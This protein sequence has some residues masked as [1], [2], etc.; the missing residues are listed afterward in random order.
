VNLSPERWQ[1]IA[2]I[3]QLAVEVAPAAR[4]AFLSE[5]CGSDDDLRREV[6]SL[7]RQD[8]A[9]V[10][11]DRSVWSMA[12]PLLDDRFDVDPGTALG[13]Y[14]IDCRL[15]A[16]GMGEVFRATDT[17]LNRPVAVKTLPM[18][19]ALDEH[20]RARFGREAK[21]VAA[22]AHPH[23]CT[24]YDV[25]RQGL[26]D[27][28]VMEYLEG[29]TL[30]ARLEKG[31]LPL[32]VALTHAIEIASALDHAHRHGI[33]HRDL[34]PANIMLTGGG[35]KLLDFGLAKFKATA[36]APVGDAD[37]TAHGMIVGTVRYMSP[38]QIQGQET[39]A[40]SDLFS[41]GSI[42]YEMLTGKRAFEGTTAPVV[43]AA[44]IEREPPTAPLL[45]SQPPL[46]HIVRRCLVKNPNERW[47]TATDVVHELKWVQR[48]RQSTPTDHE[49]TLPAREAIEPHGTV[50]PLRRNVRVALPWVAAVIGAVAL[51]VGMETWTGRGSQDPPL[52]FLIDA[53][54]GA[55]FGLA[56]MLPTPALSPD[57]RHLAFTADSQSQSSLWVQTLG[58]LDARL[59]T[60][61]S[62]A[63][64]QTAFPFW[65]PDGRFVA[66]GAAGRLKRIPVVGGGAS[67]DLATLDGVLAGGAWSRNGTIIFS[68]ATGLFRVSSTGGDKTRVTEI[69]KTRDEIAHRFPVLLPDGERFIYL[70]V[71]TRDEHQG[72]YLGSLR[73]PQLKRRVVATDA[74]G[75][76]GI[77]PDGKDHLFF[78]RDST[79]LAQPFDSSRGELNGDPVA[80]VRPI[81]P[82]EGGRFAPFA[83]SGRVLVYRPRFRPKTR[84]VWLDRRGIPAGTLGVPGTYYRSPS[85]SPDETKVAVSHLDERTGVED[86]WWF[87]LARGV[88]ERLTTE[89]VAARYPTWFP[90]GS[91][92]VFLAPRDNLWRLIANSIPASGNER[93]LF[94]GPQTIMRIRD[95]TPDGRLLLF[96]RNND[97]W[98]LPL[99]AGREEYP[100]IAT[101]ATENH[102]RVS[103]NGRWLAFT[104]NVTG[105]SQVYVTS[106]PVPGERI[107]IS[108]TGGS[109]PQWRN[110]GRELF[111]V[112]T[113][114][115][116]TAVP[117]QSDQTFVYG[118]P[119]SLFRASFEPFSLTF[120]SVY[121]PARDGKRFLVVEVVEAD[122]PRL[123]AAINWTIH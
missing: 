103:P 65:S 121:A 102:G 37:V 83:V 3:Y 20:K 79:L 69:D 48:S 104:S 7:L 115:T 95:L 17:R 11:V 40:R 1:H 10:V 58:S 29:D 6:D 62:Q 27:Y 120:G 4:N 50:L 109:D 9:A 92:V 36:T 70:V 13:P 94:T 18:H 42:L 8:D 116:F 43:G 63:A 98:A 82:G 105:E 38:E 56:T 44:L 39:D 108:Q 30:A 75:A 78:V 15:G 22:L 32:D 61:T 2:R 93:L 54:E 5:T 66:F 112:S 91:G 88:N 57:G 86:V 72:L 47:Q 68:D 114:G 96:Q 123:T 16:G 101:P 51:G 90:D 19:L 60:V 111:F 23:I 117:V 33:I 76:L 41:F 24:L 84:L 71:G 74:N 52:T 21:A 45:Q 100:L 80:V 106:F 12:V 99:D 113:D 35:A 81:E 97:L 53:P 118:T 49:P 46:D 85:L 89:R 110:D 59:L 14:L 87:D 107:R 119:E 28:I 55:S 77:G 34:K 64:S 26:V 73:D 25:G 31:P 122:E 67:Q